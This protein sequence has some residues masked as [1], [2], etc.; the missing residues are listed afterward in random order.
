MVG[1]GRARFT[2]TTTLKSFCMRGVLLEERIP[3]DG[4]GEGLRSLLSVDRSL[5]HHGCVMSLSGRDD[6]LSQWRGYGGFGNA[7]TTG[8]DTEALA[9]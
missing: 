3:K 1:C 8:F 6:D 5:R 9:K 4:A 7:Y 2:F